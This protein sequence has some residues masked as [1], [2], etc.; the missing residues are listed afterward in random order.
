[1]EAI[2]HFVR[3]KVHELQIKVLQNKIINKTL[4]DSFVKI[5]VIQQAYFV[6]A[7]SKIG[8]IFQPL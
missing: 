1:M 2:L 8:Y 3:V 5:Q 4:L 7:L 6:T